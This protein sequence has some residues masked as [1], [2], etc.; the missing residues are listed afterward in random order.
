MPVGI[1]GPVSWVERWWTNPES[2]T[3]HQWLVA[4][5]ALWLAHKR[6]EDVV[7]AWQRTIAAP[8]A[9][10]RRWE[11]ARWLPLAVA[12]LL[13]AF[14]HL[15]HVA[16][17]ATIGLALAPWAVVRATHGPLV[18]R[19]LAPSWICMAALAMPPETV[20]TRVNEALG[21]LVCRGVAWVCGLGGFSVEATG[22]SLRNGT[23]I[24]ALQSSGGT[25]AA[26]SLAVF[27]V[28]VDGLARR[29]RMGE[30]VFASAMATVAAFVCGV[31]RATFGAVA[32]EPIARGVL[33]VPG[34]AAAPIAFAFPWLVRR[35]ASRWKLRLPAPVR[36]WIDALGRAVRTVLQPIA[37]R[38]RVLAAPLRALVR[39]TGLGFDRL[40]DTGGRGVARAVSPFAWFSSV[41]EGWFRRLDRRQARRRRFRP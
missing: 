1:D 37:K 30:V 38:S 36:R 8:T 13:I 14:A 11:R 35:F 10:L 22:W 16:T 18:A 4:P 15:A 3:V 40:A 2:P 27:A 24:L 21:T 20:P 9:L 41:L 32:P 31:A 33:A 25:A 17:V 5:A 12:L 29:R 23:R 7:A 6:R 34:I 26:M 39:R 28:L 19:A